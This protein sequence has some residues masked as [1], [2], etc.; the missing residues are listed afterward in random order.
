MRRNYIGLA[1]TYHDSAIAIVDHDGN[2][3]FAEGTERY[4]QNKR[5][6][7]CPADVYARLRDLV[8]AHLDRSAE[9]VVALTWTDRSAAELSA[10]LETQSDEPPEGASPFE[11]LV[12]SKVAY[13]DRSQLHAQ[14]AAGLGLQAVLDRW[15]PPRR[16]VRRSYEH[17][18]CHAAA[19]CLS[20]P[21]SEATCA[22]VDG[23]G[24]DSS[25][26]FYH[27]RDGRLTELDRA[28]R[29]PSAASLGMFYALICDMCGFDMH[30]GEEWKVMGLAPYGAV[31]D[32]LYR[33][34]DRLIEVDGLT[35]RTADRAAFDHYYTRWRSGE[36]RVARADLAHTGQRVFE[37]KLFRLLNNLAE[38]AGASSH[39]VLGGGCGLN[40]SATGKLVERTA[41]SDVYVFCAPADD[42][43][44]VGAALLAYQDD[45]RERVWPP[46]IRSPYLGSSVHPETLGNLVRFGGPAAPRHIPGSAPSRAAELLAQGKIIAWFRGPAEFGPRALGNR[47]ILAHPGIPD[48]KDQINARVKFREEF[49]PGRSA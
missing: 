15:D 40:S 33:A 23:F 10:R 35:L 37:D 41:F 21:F 11:R 18:L 22:V 25:T 12:M 43:N 42:G 29:A 30:L 47:S 17:H 16:L 49:R 26:N 1:N 27:Y 38:I 3:V 28:M 46:R 4:T 9:T 13:I 2:L 32:E 8:A 48:I 36:V 7:H 14:R 24:E 34:F 19:A 5:A 31:D 45:H 44:A 6:F 39:L 20:S